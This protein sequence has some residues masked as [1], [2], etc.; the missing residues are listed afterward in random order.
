M[1]SATRQGESFRLPTRIYDGNGEWLITPDEARVVLARGYVT[2]DG[3]RAE[4]EHVRDEGLRVRVRVQ[5]KREDLEERLQS[6][7]VPTA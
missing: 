4:I 5:G 2:L 6:G 7:D 3:E 1:I